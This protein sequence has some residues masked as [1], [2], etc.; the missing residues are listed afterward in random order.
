MGEVERRSLGLN[1]LPM[2]VT[3]HPIGGL[4]KDSVNEK[5]EQLLELIVQGLT[6]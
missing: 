3:Y 2:A 6:R 5:A 4:P 1:E